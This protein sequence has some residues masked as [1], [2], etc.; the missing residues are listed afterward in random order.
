MFRRRRRE[1]PEQVAEEA[2]APQ[3]R[4][5]GPWDAE[6]AHPEADRVD[7]GGLRL[8]VSP[9]LDVQLAVAGDQPVGVIV[10]YQESALQLHAFAAPKRSGLWDDVRTKLA[11]GVTDA[12]GTTEERQGPFGTELFGQVPG[13]GGTPQ[14]VRYLGIDGPRW[15]LRAVISG[16][17]A[18]DETIAARLEEVIGDVVVVRGE[19][20][21][22]PEEAIVLRLPS[23]ARAAGADDE[24]PK[25]NPFK[26]GPEIS[27]LR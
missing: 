19:E 1:E 9:D 5:S 4:E 13:D 22:A 20:P 8:T 16:R 6:E 26:R 24:G 12:G 10:L 23:E 3:T 27:E 25:L 18:L 21:M 11:A 17:A 15:F 14:P 2:A 7:L